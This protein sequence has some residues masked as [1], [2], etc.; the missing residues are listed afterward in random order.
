MDYNLPDKFIEFKPRWYKGID[1]DREASDL[2]DVL[3]HCNKENDIQKY[4]KDNKKWFIPAS[5]FENYDFGH[6]EAY[7]R[8]EQSLGAEYRADYMLI[9]RNSIGHHIVLIEFEDVNV[10]YR[11]SQ[12]SQ[13]SAAVRQGLSQIRDWKRWMD[14]NR[15][16]FMQSSGLK[17]ISRNIPTWGIYYCLVVSRRSRLDEEANRMRGQS[18]HETPGLK[19]ITYDRLVNNVRLLYN[20]F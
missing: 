17:N 1:F 4:I 9:G 11:L 5:I 10:D 20:G 15:S 6:H 3:N 2:L 18:Q 8:P 13:E 16:Y 12:S 19:I 14:D 7:I